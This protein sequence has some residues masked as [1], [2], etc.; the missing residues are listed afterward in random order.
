MRFQDQK[1]MSTGSSKL[2]KTTVFD[3]DKFMVENMHLNAAYTLHLK[4]NLEKQGLEN[5]ILEIL[6]KNI[7]TT[8]VIGSMLIKI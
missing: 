7:M 6:K 8:E 3:K 4:K 2:I 1:L 5:P